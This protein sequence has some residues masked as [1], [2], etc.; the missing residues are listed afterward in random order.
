[1]QN[2]S[3][4]GLIINILASNTYPLGVVI[5]EFADDSDAIDI[6]SLQIGDTAMGLN[7]DLI[8]WSK[9]NPIEASISVIPLSVSD[10]LLNILL[11]AN[12]VGRG[13]IGAKDII[14]MNL[15]YPEGNFVT[16]TTGSITDGNPVPSVASAGRI[17]SRTYNF[18]FEGRIGA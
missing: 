13:K 5:T 11:E 10:T 16:L 15:L 14:T 12:R 1:M 18:S 4:F 17:K 8:S 3:G 7:G 2:I 6:P 9:A